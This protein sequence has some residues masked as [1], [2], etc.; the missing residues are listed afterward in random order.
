MIFP[1]PW[2][3]IL[4]CQKR[5][6]WF[7]SIPWTGFDIWQPDTEW[8]KLTVVFVCIMWMSRCM[9]IAYHLAPVCA[10]GRNQ[11]GGGSMMP[12]AIFCFDLGSWHSSGCYFE[13]FLNN[14][15]QY[16]ASCN[17][18]KIYQERFEKHDKELKNW[19]G[20]KIPQTS[21]RSSI[22]GMCCTCPI[23]KS[24]TSHL[25]NLK[26]FLMSWCQTP[27]PTYRGLVESMP[28]QIRAVLVAQY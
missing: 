9:K 20:L 12:C 27:Q 14:L 8:R 1:L 22:C 19:I 5:F 10:M 15:Q 7:I 17:I 23:Y 6:P 16:N 28:H 26:D 24:P 18:A 25:I 21:P 11:A 2:C 3:L 13:T 4:E